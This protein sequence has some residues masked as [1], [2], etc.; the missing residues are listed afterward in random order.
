ML[1]E[2][3]LIVTFLC[4]GKDHIAGLDLC[5]RNAGSVVFVMPFMRHDKFAVS[6]KANEK[7]KSIFNYN[8]KRR[9]ISNRQ[10]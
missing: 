7:K 9:F 6:T 4:R 3:K 8:L 5:L 2:R 10:I 1:K